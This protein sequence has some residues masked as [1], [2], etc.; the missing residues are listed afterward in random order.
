MKKTLVSFL[1]LLLV[2]T[3]CSSNTGGSGSKEIDEL[4]IFF[5]PSRDSVKIESTV[6]PIKQLVIDGLADQGYTVGKV[7]IRISQN[8]EGA[9]EALA[10]GTAHIGFIPGGTYAL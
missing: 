3:G 10:N 2:L 9:G 4:V 6:E 5:V 7:D 8:Y 1:V